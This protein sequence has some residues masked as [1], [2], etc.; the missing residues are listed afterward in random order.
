MS[1]ER[2]FETKTKLNDAD[3][4]QQTSNEVKSEPVKEK[5]QKKPKEGKKDDS[6]PSKGKGKGDEYTLKCAKVQFQTP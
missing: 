6:K 2:E 1:L 3:A 5:S 4:Q